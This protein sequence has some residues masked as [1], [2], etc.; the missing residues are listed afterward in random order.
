MNEVT[1]TD[2]AAVARKGW[3]EVVVREVM[4][5]G[6]PRL[7]PEDT[8]IDAQRLM[9]ESRMRALPVIQEGWLKGVI[10]LEDITRMYA[11]AHGR[12]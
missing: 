1:R 6:F 7:T 12:A 4:K 5:T 11:L 2:I 3:K 8:L 9:A 10:T